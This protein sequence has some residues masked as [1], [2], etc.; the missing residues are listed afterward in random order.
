MNGQHNTQFQDLG[1]AIPKIQKKIQG[2]KKRGMKASISGI[3]KMLRSQPHLSLIGDY[4]LLWVIMNET[5][6]TNKIKIKNALKYSDEY[7]HLSKREKMWWMRSLSDPAY[8]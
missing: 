1:W 2:N 7:K 8:K 5:K 4:P 3:F 6:E